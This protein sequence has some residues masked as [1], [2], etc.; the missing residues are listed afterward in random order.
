V[1]SSRALGEDGLEFGERFQRTNTTG[2]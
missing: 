2:I 1:K